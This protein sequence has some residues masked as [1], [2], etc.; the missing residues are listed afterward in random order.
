MS[1]ISQMERSSSQT[2]ILATRTSHCGSQHASLMGSGVGGN[3][4]AG[5]KA[6][7]SQNERSSLPRLGSRP[8]LAAM[9][10]HNLIDNGQ[11]E[12]GA[13]LEIRLKGLE[14]FF[15]LLRAHPRSGVRES[16]LPVFSQG[17]DSH[18]K[19]ASALCALDALCAFHGA[20]RI[21]TEIP[22]HLFELVAIGD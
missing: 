20:H 8:N 17:F 7:Q 9:R 19:H 12:P 21:L 16:D 4:Q 18:R 15:N 11:P 13:A 1:S 2:R 5:L 3:G 6:V 14:D 22:K 10:L